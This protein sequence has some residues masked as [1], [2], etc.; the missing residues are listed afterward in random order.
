VADV[1]PSVMRIASLLLLVLV[2]GV[3][4][5]G[6]SGVSEADKAKTATKFKT[7]NKNNDVNHDATP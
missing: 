3:V 7:M 6:C 2:A 4:V 1:G 5:A